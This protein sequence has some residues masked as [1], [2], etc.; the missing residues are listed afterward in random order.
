MQY[1]KK[2]NVNMTFVRH[3][4]WLKLCLLIQKST[5]ERKT[6]WTYFPWGRTTANVL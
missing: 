5:S 3:L 2:G 4:L 6:F 1:V